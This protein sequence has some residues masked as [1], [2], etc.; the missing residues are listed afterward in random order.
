MVLGPFLAIF[1]LPG[2]TMIFVTACGLAIYYDKYWKPELLCIMLVIYICGELWE[3][4]VSLF[5]IRKEKASWL[6]CC[7]IGIG[8]FLGAVFGTL[9]L[10]VIGSFLG[11]V[12]GAFITAFLVEYYRTR[13][14][15][16]A[17]HLAW[18]SAKMRFLAILG[19][20][21]AGIALA[22]CLFYL[23]FR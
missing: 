1:D 4:F 19:K 12:V 8:A 2:N 17:Y 18:A 3:F 10:P 5:G 9:V 21:S 22:A 15:A 16:N 20:F 11:G 13:S 14:K 23:T 6:T 7:V